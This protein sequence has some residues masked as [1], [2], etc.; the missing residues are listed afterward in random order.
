VRSL[1]DTFG[2]YCFLVDSMSGS[3]ILNQLW[4]LAPHVFSLALVHLKSTFIRKGLLVDD[5]IPNKT[6]IRLFLYSKYIHL[7]VKKALSSRMHHI[8][9]KYEM[10]RTTTY[11]LP[12]PPKPHLI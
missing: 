12:L 6:S 10:M 7:K 1:R 3:R 2:F 9:P 8:H 4:K 11:F 5:L